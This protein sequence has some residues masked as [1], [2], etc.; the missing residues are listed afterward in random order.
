MHAG[1]TKGGKDHIS[2]IIKF[3]NVTKRFQI[4]AEVDYA[5]LEGLPFDAAQI[6]N[7]KL[8]AWTLSACWRAMHDPNLAGKEEC[9]TLFKTC[10]KLLVRQRPRLG[11]SPSPCCCCLQG[12]VYGSRATNK[13]YVHVLFAHLHEAYATYGV[14]LNA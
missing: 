9:E 4:M 3:P 6:N 12:N 11:T 13:W 7:Y 14:M 2:Y 1:K 10:A 8:A 5:N